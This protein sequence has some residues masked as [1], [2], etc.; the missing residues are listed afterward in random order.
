MRRSSLGKSGALALL[1]GLCYL[2]LDALSCFVG[3]GLTNNRSSSVE[4]RGYRLD[5]MLEATDGDRSLQTSEGFWI[6]EKGFEKSQWAQ[7]YRYR[8]RA[9]PEEFKKGIDCPAP[10]QI[11]PIKWKVGECFGGSGNNDKLRQ[12]KKELAQA[13]LDD[14]KKL[15]E[16][17][18]WLKRYGRKRWYPKYVNQSGAKNQ[19]GLLRGL[20]AWSGY[21]PLNEER[22]KT[23][24]EADYGKPL[25]EGKKDYR[26]P[27]RPPGRRYAGKA[28]GGE[29]PAVVV[30]NRGEGDKAFL[31]LE[32]KRSN[33]SSGDYLLP[34]VKVAMDSIDLTIDDAWL[35]PLQ[36]W[37]DQLRSG[38][39][40]RRGFRFAD[41]SSVAGQSVLEGYEPPPLPAVIQ[42]DN[43]FIS[44]VDLTVWCALKLRTVRFLPQWIR[45]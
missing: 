19:Q 44:K 35:D 39:S 36:S 8:M 11:G 18:Y 25:I 4:M 42:V 41:I 22:G 33:S 43:F 40:L 45:T 30:A 21:D 26:L 16:N 34:F 15:A 7:G 31:V 14:P 1:L 29:C 5:R 20:A 6:G 3:A 28:A 2:A 37:A 13:G 17:E 12:L 32:L 24:I 38:A 9:S 10:L 27:G 23:W